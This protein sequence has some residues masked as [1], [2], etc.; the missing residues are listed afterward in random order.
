MNKSALPYP[1]LF[2]PVLFMAFILLLPAAHASDTPT[3]PLTGNERTIAAYQRSY[4]RIIK[5]LA[6]GNLKFGAP[7]FIRI[8]KQSKELELWMRNENNR[9]A[10]YKTFAICHHSGEL[11]PKLEEGDRQSPEGFYRVDSG[12]LHPLSEYHLAFNLGYPND[13][14]LAH[15][16]TGGALMI[17]GRCSSVGCF[18]MTDYYMDEIYTLVNAAL[19]SG[20]KEMKVH[21][22][23]FRLTNENLARHNKSPWYSF[24]LN[25]KEGYDFFERYR[26]PPLV[27]VLSK[28][29]VFSTALPKGLVS[30]SS[31][32]SA[33]ELL[34]P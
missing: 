25:L 4:P 33:Q 12:Q 14:D 16:R 28:K 2:F 32:G 18:A 1:S 29:Y 21:I 9:F 30:K 27:D 10:L 23:P 19:A 24:W 13:Y 20:Q 5:M 31:Q 7:V 8:F 22:F 17:H 15:D 26:L 6:L 3:I 34:L 11:G